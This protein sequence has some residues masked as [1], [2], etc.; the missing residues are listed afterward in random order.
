MNVQTVLYMVIPC[1]NEEAVLPQTSGMFLNELTELVNKGKI[2]N[3]SRIMFVND[4]SRDRTWEIICEL[5]QKD[6]HFIGIS[7]SRNRGHQNAVLA[8]LMEAK[9]CCDITISI[10]CDGQ[11]D[12][13][14]MEAMVDAYHD[15]CEIVYGVRSKRAT[16]TF[17]KR[18]TAES[19]YKLLKAMGA[20]V[21]FNHADYRLMSSRALQEFAKF[22]EVNLFLRGM[23]PLVGFKST[24]VSYERH[25][26]LAGQ[27][28][29]PLRKMLALAFDGITSLS[30]KPIRMITF[31]GILFFVISLIGILW[32]VI[33][34]LCG[35]SVPGWASTACIVL[36]MGGVQ[37]LFLGVIGEYVGKIYMEVTARPRYI[38]S[39][40]T[41][42]KV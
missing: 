24:C 4:G 5:A 32:S 37:S 26:R 31:A 7:Q 8:G 3:D 38:I 29:Y 15:G 35:H 1:Y 27:S 42:E 10:D 22:K 6:K 36:L 16:D 25:E 30:V 40:R 18:F 2:S 17:F 39:E 21:V 19:F 14:A 41:K 28:H 33:T 20:D 9:D 11:D 23:V 13:G 12:I 34:A